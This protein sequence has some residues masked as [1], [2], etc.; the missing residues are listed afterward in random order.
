[1]RL[2]HRAHQHHTNR[3]VLAYPIFQAFG[4]QPDLWAIHGLGESYNHLPDPLRASIPPVSPSP[5]PAKRGKRGRSLRGGGG[6]SVAPL[7]PPKSM[8]YGCISDPLKDDEGM[9]NVHL[10]RR[11]GFKESFA[12]VV[13][14]VIGTGIF[15]KTAVMAQDAG[16]PLYVLLAWL[17]A[18][19]LSFMGR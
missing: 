18:G 13:G 1:M 7:V 3:I 2:G 5:S 19:V 11:L 12:I 9:T 8:P 10:L 16:S 17:V 6:V 4:K 15:L 14:T